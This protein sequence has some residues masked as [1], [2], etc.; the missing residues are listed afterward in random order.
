MNL[1]LF[2][3]NRISVNPLQKKLLDLYRAFTVMT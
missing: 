3:E 1:W 2:N